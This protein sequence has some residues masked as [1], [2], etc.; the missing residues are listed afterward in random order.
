MERISG[1]FH[2]NQGSV[3]NI[4]DKLSNEFMKVRCK[5]S[6]AGIGCDKI[7]L[8]QVWVDLAPKVYSTAG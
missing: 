6:K 5:V 8:Q 4:A 2:V 3:A 1:T 7:G